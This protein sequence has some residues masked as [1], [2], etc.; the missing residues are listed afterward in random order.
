MPLCSDDETGKF[1]RAIAAM[2]LANM[3]NDDILVIL[4][5]QPGDLDLFLA[6]SSI[7]IN[8]DKLSIARDLIDDP[9]VMTSILFHKTTQDAILFLRDMLNGGT[10]PDVKRNY[11]SLETVPQ[12][13]RKSAAIDLVKLLLEFQKTGISVN[14]D[15]EEDGVGPVDLSLDMDVLS[16]ES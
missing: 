2:Q 10:P 15:D 3:T 1:Q 8:E 6:D 7:N 11:K 14:V 5:C 12:Q 4:A 16:K 9:E 13:L